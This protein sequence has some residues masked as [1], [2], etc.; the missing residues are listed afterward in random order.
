MEKAIK[1]RKKLIVFGVPLLIIGM[2]ILISKSSIFINY[3]NQLSIGITFDLLLTVPLIYFLLIRKTKIPKTTVIPFLVIGLITCTLILPPK[4]Q[5]YLNLFKTWVFPV[6]ELLVILLIVYKIRKV[7]KIY[8]SKKIESF[9]FYT[10]LKSTCYEILPKFAVIPVITE[11]SVFYYGFIYW[12]KRK[13]KENEFS[14]H[15]DSGTI[16]LLGATIL[17]IVVETIILHS[18]LEKWNSIVAW[19]LTCL[20][21]YSGIQFL[22]FIKSMFKRPILIE[23]GKL[24]LRYGIMSETT[25]NIKDIDSIE[26]QSKDIEENKETRKL[27]FLGELESH[28][29][30]IR[31]K[32]EAT[33][34]RLYG[35]KRKYKNLAFHVDNKNEFVTTLQAAIENPEL[36]ETPK[37]EVNEDVKTPVAFTNEQKVFR[38]IFWIIAIS[39]LF[40][41]IAFSA[42]SKKNEFAFGIST[43]IFS[44]LPAV[45]TLILNKIEKGG[46][47]ELQFIKPKLKSSVLA[48]ITPFIYFGIIMFIQYALEIR[49]LPNWNKLSSVNEL[50]INLILGYPVMLFLLMGEEIA[51]RGYLQEKLIKKFG[52]LK[53]LLLL[54]LIWGIWH[55]PISLQGHNLPN[56]PILESL[57]TTPLMCI[58]LTLIIG[59][60]GLNNKSIF[61]G[62]ILHTSNNHFGGTFLYLT[63][64]YNEFTHAMVFSIVYVLIIIVFSYLYRKKKTI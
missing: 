27:S 31:L 17:I 6:I 49:S 52:G 58:A 30:I 39:W 9:D 13:L 23:N 26:L 42:F 29:T 45:I 55:L 28:N 5:F 59:Y 47:N 15:K 21:I 37:H 36:F 62:L 7:I 12:K 48:F 38:A 20:S 51:W 11:I 16:A 19:V 22:G 34:I 18:L 1:T 35:I 40:G 60:Y 54:G 46:W 32:K 50:I 4:N 25:I 3:P 33:L 24:F 41:F 64:T 57:V 56:N 61:I 10:T 53:G 44:I 14:Y 63:E 43:L 2:M 8:K